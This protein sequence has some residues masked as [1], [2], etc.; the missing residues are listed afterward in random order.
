[1]WNKWNIT[2]KYAVIMILIKPQIMLKYWIKFS[3]LKT[4]TLIS[5]IERQVEH[6][7]LLTLIRNICFIYH[8]TLCRRSRGRK[9]FQS[10]VN[11]QIG[12]K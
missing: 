9:R 3:I 8:N 10:D 7:V 5:K 11:K 2:I 12:N 1:M 4:I 6:L